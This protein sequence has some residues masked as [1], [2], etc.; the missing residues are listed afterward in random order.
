MVLNLLAIGLAMDLDCCGGRHRRGG[1]AVQPGELS[2]TDRVLRRGFS[3]L[4]RHGDLRRFQTRPEPGIP[5]QVQDVDGDP[6]RPGGH[7]RL[8]APRLLAHCQQHLLR[9]QQLSEQ[10]DQQE[11]AIQGEVTGD[12]LT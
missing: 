12:R 5:G 4:H 7:R 2:R 11:F 10:R 6:Y 1:Q 9:D 8:P 3:V